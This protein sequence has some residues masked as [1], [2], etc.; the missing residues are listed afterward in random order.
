MC[1]V[2]VSVSACACA[3]CVCVCDMSTLLGISALVS[4]LPFQK[5]CPS[6][7]P[8]RISSSPRATQDHTYRV[9]KTWS[10]DLPREISLLSF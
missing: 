9:F 3:C 10:P 1:V 8:P 6:K 7:S 4:L 2:Y 5:A